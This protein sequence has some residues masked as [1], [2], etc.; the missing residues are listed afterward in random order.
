[1]VY[2]PAT[3]VV[4]VTTTDANGE[5][6]VLTSTGSMGLDPYVVT[7]NTNSV[8]YAAGESTARISSLITNLT[9]E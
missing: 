2:D 8:A 4:E 6:Q 5:A 9:L 7:V 3:A 1:V